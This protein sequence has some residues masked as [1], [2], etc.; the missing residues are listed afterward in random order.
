MTP[1]E[2]LKKAVRVLEGQSATAKVCAGTVKQGHVYNWL[3]R[4]KKLPP[5]Y[6]LKIQR[7]TADKG[8]EVRA[9]ELCPDV[10]SDESAA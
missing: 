9:S 3:N 8:E 1:H 4:D 6:A 7:A 2:A 5:Q 10:F